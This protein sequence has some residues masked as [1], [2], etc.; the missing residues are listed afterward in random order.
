MTYFQEIIKVVK[1]DMVC[2]FRAFPLIFI[3]NCIQATIDYSLSQ[4]EFHYVR[5][6]KGALRTDNGYRSG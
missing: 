1:G 6:L 5:E 4:G 2:I 3:S